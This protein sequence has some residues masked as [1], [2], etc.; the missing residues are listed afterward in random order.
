MATN[1][2]E[3]SNLMNEKSI[4]ICC[5]IVFSVFLLNCHDNTA[6][7]R[8]LFDF[9]SLSELDQLEW[10]CHTM[11]SISGEHPSHGSKSLKLELY[12]SARP[13]YPGLTPILKERN[14][15]AYKVLSFDIYNPQKHEA[16]IAIRIDDREYPE[17]P[18][19]YNKSIILQPGANHLSIPL[20]TAITSGTLRRLDLREIHNFLI[21]MA[22]PEKRVVLYVDY[23]R[24]INY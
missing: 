4:K 9:E 17:Y 20:N 24:L 8:V 18:D 21:F 1:K 23:I 6:K 2:S 11:Y 12:P 7:E 10:N 15:S 22:Y 14:W 3:L 13:D 5:L 16:P 19:R